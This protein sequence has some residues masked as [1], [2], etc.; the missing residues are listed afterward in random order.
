VSVRRP[1]PF[2]I[3]A[4]TKSTS[5][6]LAV[7]AR[8]VAIPTAS[9]FRRSSG[10]VLAAPRNLPS[11][12]ASRVSCRRG[13]HYDLKAKSAWGR[14]LVLLQGWRRAGHHPADSV[15]RPDRPDRVGGQALPGVQG[16][17]GLAGHAPLEAG[18]R[19]GHGVISASARIRSRSGRRSW[20]SGATVGP[21]RARG[22]QKG[23]PHHGRGSEPRALA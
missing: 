21:D 10:S 9:F 19:R 18:C 14:P 17:R 7:Q 23:H 16:L 1:L 5:P 15:V 13:P 22:P 11:E 3:D 2:M 12:R 20:A 8:P 4:S 6:P